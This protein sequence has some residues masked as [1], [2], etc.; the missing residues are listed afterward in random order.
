MGYTTIIDIIG[1]TI[2]GGFLLLILFRLN[3]SATENTYNY[4]SDLNAQ[5]SLTTMSDVIN[6]DFSKIG[7]V[8]GKAP[9]YDSAIKLADSTHFEFYADM[10]NDGNIDSVSY[11]LGPTSDLSNTPNPSDRI[12]YRTV[13]DTNP[14]EVTKFT[15]VSVFRLNYY[16]AS[17]HL[18]SFPISNLENIA[19]IQIL[20]KTENAEPMNGQY[21]SAFSQETEYVGYNITER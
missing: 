1:S 9:D 14:P 7:Y 19:R 10:N 17:S 5:Q 13:Y 21:A 12:L 18:L 6:Y 3:A 20:L 16:D 2:I 15:G 8:N 11:L 4:G